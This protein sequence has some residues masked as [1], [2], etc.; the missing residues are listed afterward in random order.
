MDQFAGRK[1]IIAVMVMVAAFILVARLF[2]IQVI[3]SSYK[4]SAENNSKRI[5]TIY[6]A[7]GLIYD[8]NHSLLVY[9]QPAYDLMIAPFELK[10]FDSIALCDLLNIDMERLRSGIARVKIPKY[11][12]DP[13]IKQLSPETYAVLQERLFRFP[14]FYVRSRTLRKYS[15]E[16][17]AH[18]L[19]YVGEVDEK[20]IE[21]NSYYVMGDYIGISGIEGYYEEFLRGEKGQEV[22]LVDVHGRVKGPYQGGR[23]D[24]DARVGSNFICTI[25]ARLQEYGE[26]LMKNYKG[27]IVA[28][29]PSTGEILTLI[30]SPSYNPSLLVGRQRS[31]NYGKL[32]S[33]SLE[34]L[35]NRALMANYPPGSTFKPVHA[36]IGLQEGV[37][38]VNSTFSCNLGYYAKGVRV[39][40]HDHASPLK[41]L[42]GIQNSCNAYFCNV[43]RRILEDPKYP[44][45]TDA[46]NNWRN[47]ILSFGFGNTLNADFTNELRGFI[48]PSS[49]YDRY[50]G[51]H[52]W[53]ALTVISLAIGQGELLITPLQMANMVACIANRGYYYIP[54]MVK[55]IEGVDTLDRRF[56]HQHK[57][58]IDTANF[59]RVVEGMYLAVNGGPGRTAGIA[60]INNIA[61]CG[62]TGTAENPHGEDHSVF[63]AFAPNDEPKIAIAVYVEHGKWGASYAA[64]IA[65]LLIEKYL[66]D[67][68]SPNRKWIEARMLSRNLLY[69]Q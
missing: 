10:S 27:S 54:H 64:P 41:L 32:E 19:G 35:F 13:F 51:E 18:V 1:N 4:L 61:V 47:H 46:Y 22:L 53:S 66:T 30:S 15:K 7:R 60:R 29:E 65:S 26:M 55:Q 40:C 9:N 31:H 8:R 24:E 59:N 25:D 3:D 67:T 42:A 63:I 14:G 37:I 6:A 23:F 34:P 33:D 45:V 69:A 44:S 16:M 12:R 68:I 36:L 17:A 21:N 58:D 2:Y 62:K 38:D 5:E 28:I 11:R 50:Y 57:V 49:Y 56:T 20:T 39:G 48:A 52:H 43:F